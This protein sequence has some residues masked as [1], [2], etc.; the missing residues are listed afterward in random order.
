MFNCFKCMMKPKPKFIEY[1]CR[2]GEFK[3]EIWI[4]ACLAYEIQKLWDSGIHTTGCCCGHGT[5]NGFIQVIDD[6]IVKMEKLGYEHY[7]YPNDK[8][9]LDAFIPKS[10]NHYYHGYTDCYL[11]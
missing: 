2:K 7:I 4:D 6:D 11:G 9:R 8:D 5:N 10:K 1:N 3:D